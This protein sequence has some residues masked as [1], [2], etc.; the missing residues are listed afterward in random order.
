[1][2]SCLTICS[3]FALT[4]VCV[5]VALAQPAGGPPA[6]M[7]GM[8]G[9]GATQVGYV[10]LAAEDVP[11]TTTLP[12]RVSPSA[13]AQVRPQ[14]G[15][16]IT[17]V[18]VTEG[19]PVLAGDLLLTIDDKTYRAEL[20]VAE[21]S[22]ASVRAQL[23]SAQSKVTRYEK[24]VGS[25]GVTETDL[26]TARVELAQAEAAVQSA[27]AQ[28]ELKQISLEQTRITAP[29]SGMLGTVNAE[30]GQLVTAGQADAL[31]TVRTTDPVY[32]ELVESSANL[33]AMRSGSGEP[34]REGEQPTPQVHVTLED[35]TL[36][37]QVGSISS[38]DFVVSETTGTITV[39]A[40]MPNPDQ[41]LLPGMFVRAHIAVGEQRDAYLVPQRAVTFNA[42]GEATAYFVSADN[43]VEQRVLMA[44][45]DMNNAWVVTAGVA[46][47]D[48][49][50]VDGL[51]KIS[52]GTAVTPVPVTINEDGVIIQDMSAS[53]A[54][55]GAPEGAT[56]P[57]D[58]ASA[59]AD[60]STQTTESA[61]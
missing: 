37:D 50:I 56:P 17:A 12:G 45:R 25:G 51:Q 36:F 54:P 59:P 43:T 10:V 1:M 15:G 47:G 32:V 31:A 3:V 26:E 40:T 19:T 58:G 34:P 53:A 60:G 9:M 42:R 23:P 2:K 24:L 49:L 8:P 5:P 13:T 7:S 38:A 22:L 30:V 41:I 35:G 44:T 4:L 20:A 33:L 48:R 28:L 21:A 29:I 27:E 39:R 55:M 61:Q 52:D 11:L 16:I 14:V 6:G 46:E 57:G 18:A